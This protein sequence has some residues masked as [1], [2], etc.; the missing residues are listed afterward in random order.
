[1]LNTIVTLM[2]TSV[3]SL[4]TGKL[5]VKVLKNVTPIKMCTNTKKIRVFMVTINK[6]IH[7]LSSVF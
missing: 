4:R 7:I 6:A 3:C 5:I 2:V 1:M